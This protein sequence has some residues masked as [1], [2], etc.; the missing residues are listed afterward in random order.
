MK[1]SIPRADHFNEKLHL[2]SIIFFKLTILAVLVPFD[3]L[4]LI[5]VANL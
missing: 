5:K 4:P 2:A 3:P 1:I